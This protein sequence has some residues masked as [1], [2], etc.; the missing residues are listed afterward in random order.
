MKKMLYKCGD[1]AAQTRVNITTYV[2]IAT[3]IMVDC[4]VVGLFRAP[5][6]FITKALL[7]VLS[8]TFS[9]AFC[10]MKL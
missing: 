5:L 7:Q 8:S 10:V 2:N 1:I 3:E 6:L 9:R 4:V